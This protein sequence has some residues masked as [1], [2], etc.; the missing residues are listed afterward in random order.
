MDPRSFIFIPDDF[1]L[2]P[3]LFH[4]SEKYQGFIRTLYATAETIHNRVQSLT[5]EILID[6]GDNSLVI[7]C[8]LEGGFRF[9]KDLHEFIGKK[10]EGSNNCCKVKYIRVKSHSSGQQK[11]VVI[12]GLDSIDIEGKYVLIV[13]DLVDSG[14][15]LYKISEIIRKKGP[16]YLKI[17]VSAYKRNPRNTVIMPDFIGFSIPNEAVIG[18]CMDFNGNF[19][20][21]EHI[22][23]LNDE[24]REHF[25]S[26]FPN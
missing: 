12:D 17:A 19:R 14:N 24:G 13:D 26:K 7:L 5:E 16:A 22:A 1:E 25:K 8:I 21:F 23:A 20:D 9:C 18:Y 10:R 2:S 6:C 4:I 3:H 11:E 15:T